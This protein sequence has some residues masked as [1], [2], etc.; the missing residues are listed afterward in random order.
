MSAAS[1]E[2]SVVRVLVVEDVATMA[3][4]LES[5]LRN[6]GMDVLCAPSGAAAMAARESFKPEIVLVDLTLPDTHGMTLVRVFS[7]AGAGVI[8]VTASSEEAVRVAALD[9][10]ADD[11]VVK[12]V[13]VHEL[14]ARIRA[15]HRR[16]QGRANE[17]AAT[18]SDTR[19][20]VD[21]SHRQLV[22][23]DGRISTLTEAEML[24][25]EALLAADRGPVTREQISKVA[26]KRP[27]HA[28]DRSV[29]Q[30]MM[31]LRRKL[32]DL[33]CPERTIL[34][35]RREGYVLADPDLFQSGPD[36]RV[37]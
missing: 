12:P 26:L 11:Y 19:I 17:A 20:A 14:T 31:K 15:V 29:D 5:A 10:G 33:G 25:F 9:I 13:M 4:M 30:L 2:E 6:A 27:V 21:S 32:S 35:V 37:L 36:E 1:I 18:E 23:Q 28:E 34:S 22:A 24:A 8:V 3:T 7:E 16:L